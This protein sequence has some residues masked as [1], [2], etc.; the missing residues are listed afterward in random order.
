[1][2]ALLVKETIILE[3]TSPTTHFAFKPPP[4]N[5]VDSQGNVVVEAAPE[6]SGGKDNDRIRLDR[7]QHVPGSLVC[8]GSLGHVKVATRVCICRTIKSS[9]RIAGEVPGFTVSQKQHVYTHDLQKIDRSQRN[10][11]S[12]FLLVDVLLEKD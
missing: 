11:R 5:Y 10:V 3:P 7:F 1:M 8:R 4:H 2:G 12:I 6:G 9:K